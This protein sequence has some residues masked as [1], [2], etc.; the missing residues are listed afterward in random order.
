MS[1]VES[2]FGMIGGHYEKVTKVSDAAVVLEV[3][4]FLNRTEHGSVQLA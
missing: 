3:S 4:R 1:F 2:H